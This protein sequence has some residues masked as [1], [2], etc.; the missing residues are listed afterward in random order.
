[1]SSPVKETGAIA[2]D[3]DAPALRAVATSISGVFGA[4][5]TLRV[6]AVT[7]AAARPACCNSSSERLSPGELSNMS[8]GP[9]LPS[10]KKKLAGG[11][12]CD[13]GPKLV[14]KEDE[15]EELVDVLLGQFLEMC[16]T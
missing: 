6:V 4:A 15:A 14:G 3:A 7:S 5:P 16:P 13:L 9:S 2:L 8:T 12:G 10:C 11:L 1:M